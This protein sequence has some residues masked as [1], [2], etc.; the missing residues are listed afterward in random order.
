MRWSGRARGQVQVGHA[1][2]LNDEPDPAGRR[3][4]EADVL[5]LILLR[6][7]PA[8]RV[9]HGQGNRQRHHAAAWMQETPGRT[10]VHGRHI[11]EQDEGRN[12]RGGGLTGSS[13][14][15][16]GPAVGWHQAISAFKQTDLVSL[17]SPPSGIIFINSRRGG[18]FAGLL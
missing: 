15:G 5:C 1:A 8:L 13:G 16:S 4:L 17:N 7:E 10:G 3:Q 11:A 2:T 6:R 9:H 18:Y 12:E 14:T